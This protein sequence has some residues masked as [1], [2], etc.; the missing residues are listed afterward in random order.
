[1]PNVLDVLGVRTLVDAPCGDMNWMRHLK[2]SFKRFIGIDAVPSIVDRL[3]QESFPDEY[4]FQ[5]GNIVTDILP[6]ADALFCR[7]C[8]V[9]LPFA[10]IHNALRLW[11][12]AGFKHV[13]A[14]TF[15]RHT[16][17]T[18]CQIGGWR[19]L[20]LQAAPFFLPDPAHI[21]PDNEGFGEDLNDKAIGVWI[22]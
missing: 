4:H 21:V 11:K 19:T 14:T 20:N 8:L 13:M 16:Q 10:D 9:H 5:T 1:L 17:N 18:D 2:Y 12:L 6:Q 22:L 3:K 15:T 7:D